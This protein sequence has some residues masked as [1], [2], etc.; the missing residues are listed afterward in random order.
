MSVVEPTH[1]AIREA[2][3]VQAVFMQLGFLAD[4]LYFAAQGGRTLVVVRRDGKEF[5]YDAGPHAPI[6]K[7][8]LADTWRSAAAWWNSLPQPERHA[9]VDASE[10][11]KNLV[12]I[13]TALMAKGFAIKRSDA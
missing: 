6:P 3:A 4:H 2:L 9:F 1:T 5:I 13:M 7:E 12:I 11:R 8:K 10:S